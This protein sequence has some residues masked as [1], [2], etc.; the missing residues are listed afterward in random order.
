MIEANYGWEH[1]AYL[2]SASL[3]DLFTLATD[4]EQR[5]VS[6]F[7]TQ[8]L[9]VRAVAPIF[10]KQMLL[11]TRWTYVDRRW[12]RYNPSE[13]DV[14]VRTEPAVLWDLVLSGEEARYGVGYYVGAYNLFD[15]RYALPV[16]FEFRQRTMPQLGRS[17]VAGIT[18]QR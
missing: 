13:S 16:G 18:W 8:I 11:G 15:W 4:P 17:I 12:T 9:G 3:G 14:Q 5:H 7:P 6:N 1:V 10:S 2:K